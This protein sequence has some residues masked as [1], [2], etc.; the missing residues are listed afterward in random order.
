MF[1]MVHEESK[2]SNSEIIEEVPTTT[3]LT[4]KGGEG[5]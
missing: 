3:V 5:S 2:V 4:A 1:G